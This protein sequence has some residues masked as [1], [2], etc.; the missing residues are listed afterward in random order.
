[1]NW[2]IAIATSQEPADAATIFFVDI[3]VKRTGRLYLMI[4]VK[5][6]RL[7]CHVT[8]VDEVDVPKSNYMLLLLL[9]L[10]LLRILVLLLLTIQERLG[11]F[12]V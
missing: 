1:M 4:V 3:G 8:P 2:A 7:E 6:N 5:T 10:P 11:G 9:L 12:S